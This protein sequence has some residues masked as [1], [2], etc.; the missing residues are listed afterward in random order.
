MEIVSVDQELEHENLNA[1]TLE[2]L[3]SDAN[4]YSVLLL[5]PKGVIEATPDHIRSHDPDQSQAQFESF[6]VKAAE[7]QPALIVTPEYSMPWQLLK[8][9]ISSDNGGPHEGK[10]WVLGCESIRYSELQALK[11]ELAGV[12]T[13]LFEPMEAND[14]RFV[15]PLAY[16]FRAPRSDN[17]S[18]TRLVVLVQFKTRAMADPLDFERNLLQNGTRIYRF[19]RPGSSISLL[20][21]ICS[22]M[23]DFNDP[24]ALMVHDRALILHIQ[25]QPQRQHSV[26]LG[27]RN[28]LLMRGG[29]ATEI[30]TLNWARGTSIL[31]NGECDSSP[32]FAGSAWY[33]KA[34]EIDLTDSTI[35]ANHRNG[36]YYTW[37]KSLRTHVLFFNFE[38]ALYYINASKV[39]RIGENGAESHRR[40]PE[41]VST[42]TWD[43]VQDQ[44]STNS[45]LDDGFEEMLFECGNSSEQIK[46][47][48]ET[49]PCKCER[50]LAMSAGNAC[51]SENWHKPQMLDSFNLNAEELIRRVTF[52]QPSHNDEASFRKR[53]LRGCARLWQAIHDTNGLP[54][55]LND[56]ADGFKLDWDPQAKNQNLL[57]DVGDR[58]RA[59]AMHLGES[60]KDDAEAAYNLVRQRIHVEYASDEEVCSNAKQRIAVW[61][62]DISGERGLVHRHP[63][64][65]DLGDE[66]PA[67]IGRES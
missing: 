55:A 52:C 7:S 17:S 25:L 9:A 19:G 30:L 16:I 22:D 28:R 29:D 32:K 20:S 43:P 56:L 37:M 3:V 13:L 33:V 36:L 51:R 53:R 14:A 18:E 44:W 64:I 62:T 5:Q 6:L 45:V 63:R 66:S 58:G 23:L 49:C 35:T 41:I 24:A 15:D 8:D 47:I 38:P 40:G 1:P 10:L 65:D 42:A 34:R 4:N 2:A 67:D 46:A 12:A 31:T 48:Y 39:V 11:E 54:S 57:P 27:F 26:A 60:S 21:F 61:Y 59:T 50:L